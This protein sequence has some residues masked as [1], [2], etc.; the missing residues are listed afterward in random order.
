MLGVLLLH[1]VPSSSFISCKGFHAST[2]QIDVLPCSAFPDPC[3]PHP[4]PHTM[5]PHLTHAA[6][7]CM[8]A[9]PPIP[10]RPVH[11]LMTNPA[12]SNRWPI[13]A[14]RSTRLEYEAALVGRPVTSPHR[15]SRAPAVTYTTAPHPNYWSPN[16]FPKHHYH[17][18]HH[19][20]C[21][22]RFR[23]ALEYGHSYRLFWLCSRAHP[24][25]FNHS[26]I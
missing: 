16:P 11:P 22:N 17:Q 3:T 8:Q 15:S 14:L 26:C 25:I 6:T 5:H 9:W 19:Q 24:L 23:V 20:H 4:T 10:A 18:P 13:H 7:A 1:L 12:D 2:Y 21:L